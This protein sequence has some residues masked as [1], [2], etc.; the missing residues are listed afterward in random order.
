MTGA[1]DT[2]R[3]KARDLLSGWKGEAYAFGLGRLG[4]VGPLAACAGGDNIGGR[5]VL[6]ANAS[7]WMAPTLTAVEAALADAGVEVVARTR[8]ARPNSP[9]DDVYRMQDAI[10]AAAPDRVVAVGGGSTIDAAKAG[11]VLATLAGGAHDIE[12]YFG[13]GRVTE[14]LAK[15][16]AR[17]PAFVAV[18]NAAGSAAHLTR[19]SN[20]TDPATAQKKLIIDDAC[21][22]AAAVFDYALT[23]T[24]PADLTMDGAFD[25]IGHLAEAYFGATGRTLDHLEPIA[26]AGVALIVSSIAQAVEYPGDLDA[27]EALGLGTDLGGLAIMLGSTNGPHLNSFSLVDLLAHGRAC[28]VL[29]PYYTVLFAPAIQRQLRTLGRLYAAAGLTDADLDRLA[30]RDL[31]VAVAEAMMALSRRVGF[32][33]TLGEIPGF[34]DAHVARALAAAKDPQLASKLQAMPVGLAPEQVDEVMGSV[35]AAATDGDLGKIA[36]L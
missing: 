14:A 30:G 25:G 4:R 26:E 29:L 17:L 27:R 31:A 35:L 1:D 2:I 9:R 16:G 33:T 36:D 5:A 19:Y 32:P 3:Q 10:A 23:R 34:G 21:V 28:A 15:R 7:A 24:A 13:V 12:P 20:I 8:G 6:V 11:V 18:Q 22:P